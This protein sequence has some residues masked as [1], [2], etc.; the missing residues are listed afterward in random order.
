MTIIKR[1]KGALT[2]S[3]FE[4]GNDVDTV[5]NR[6]HGTYGYIFGAALVL[7]GLGA[8]VGP[9]LAARIKGNAVI[10]VTQAITIGTVQLT[11][12]NDMNPPTNGRAY[13]SKDDTNTRFT[14]SA[15]LLPHPSG[16]RVHLG[17]LNAANNQMRLR[18]TLEV[19]DPIMVDIQAY[20]PSSPN[21]TLGRLD[22]STWEIAIASSPGVE[23][24]IHIDLALPNAGPPGFYTVKGKIEALQESASQTT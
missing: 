4:G 8:A 16:I 12:I 3:V 6:R 24:D 17:L 7:I 10:T 11:N 9:V 20:V 23:N 15:D 5:L 18:L 14:V 21:M 22:Q 1:A 13:T 19:P 2:G